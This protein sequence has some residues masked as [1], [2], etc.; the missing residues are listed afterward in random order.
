MKSNE[1]VIFLCKNTDSLLFCFNQTEGVLSFIQ[2]FMTYQQTLDW[3]F[4]Q[5][6]MYQRVG[7]RLRLRKDLTNITSVC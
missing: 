5:L 1:A 4:A 2:H 6:P 7:A 3:M